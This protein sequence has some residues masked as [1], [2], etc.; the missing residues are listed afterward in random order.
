MTSYPPLRRAL[1]FK[2]TG[3]TRPEGNDVGNR[4]GASAS[5]YLRLH[6][7]DPVD[8]FVWGDEAFA[9]ARALDRPLLLS[10]GYS[11]CHWCHVMQAESFKDPETAALMN[12]RYVAIKVDRELRPDVDA[13]YQDYVTATV[14]RGG[15]PLTV[16]LTPDKAPLFGGTYFPRETSRGLNGFREALSAVADAWTDDRADVDETAAAALAFLEQQAARRPEE[17]IDRTMID[18]SVDYLMQ[19]QDPRH[20]GLKGPQKF[21]QLPAIEF[22]AAYTA[23]VPDSELLYVIESAML[24]IVRGGIFDQVGG[25]VHRYAVDQEWRVPHFEKMLYDQGLLL[26]ALAWAA[27]L[28][29]SAG[30]RE[31]YARAAR[32]TAAFLRTGMTAPSGLLYAALSADTGGIEGATYTWTRAQLAA[33][34]TPDE[35]AVADEALGADDAADDGAVTLIRRQGDAGK[36]PV[37][38]AVIA[39]LAAARALRPQPD[40]DTKTLTAWNAIA[41]RGLMDAGEAFGEPEMVAHGVYLT[42]R[43]QQIAVTPNGVLREPTDPSVAHV[44]LIEDAAHLVSALLTA[45]RAAG[46]GDLLDAARDLH[47]DT[48]ERFAEG[49]ILYMTP[50]AGDLPVRPREG[51]D[52]AVP[53]GSSTT[54]QNA[55]RLGL[56]DG[57]TAQLA[58]ARAALPQVWAVADFAPEQA[59]RSLAAAVALELAG[60]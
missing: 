50:E 17:P 21:P 55:V 22:L 30:V 59:G 32:A 2:R 47:A 4:L 8:W 51:G 34:L 35:L 6:A 7:D 33:A 58:F 19:R 53:A 13:V 43:L 27:P 41:A 37:V 52:S 39:R 40:A 3:R 10:C 36:T 49:H 46:D 25:G 54:I 56:A 44:R 11:A 28:A 57:D 18:S 12:A 15:W 23:L 9:R 38:D 42:R 24:A 29:S 14:G 45:A 16:W 20:G 1:S 5:P 31:E 26:S 60:D 48:L